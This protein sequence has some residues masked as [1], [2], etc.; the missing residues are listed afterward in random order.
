MKPSVAGA[1]EVE[2]EE[3]EH[4]Q[5]HECDPF[6]SVA[7]QRVTALG[8]AGGFFESVA[9]DARGPTPVFFVTEDAPNGALRCTAVAGSPLFE[10]ERRCFGLVCPKG[11]AMQDGCNA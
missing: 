10:A 2:G 8:G 9:Y 7:T 4:G 1:V 3:V 11:S 6:G 5:I